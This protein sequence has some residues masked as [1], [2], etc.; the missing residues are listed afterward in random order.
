VVGV[1]SDRIRTA[2]ATSVHL[3]SHD[4]QPF[5]ESMPLRYAKE[6]ALHGSP[7]VEITFCNE[8]LCSLVKSCGP[9]NARGGLSPRISGDRG[10]FAPHAATPRHQ[11]ARAAR[12]KTLIPARS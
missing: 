10:W 5:T 4:S 7:A 3:T 12:P 8:R 2:Y 1:P 9:G 11:T 6:I